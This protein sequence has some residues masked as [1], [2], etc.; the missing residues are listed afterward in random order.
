LIRGGKIPILPIHTRQDRNLAAT[1][2]TALPR[3]RWMEQ[4]TLDTT[5]IPTVAETLDRRLTAPMFLLSIV[6]LAVAAGVIH[7]VGQ[8][9]F[10]LFEVHLVAWCLAVL[11]PIFAIDAFLRFFVTRAQLGVWQRFGILVIVLLFPFVRMALRSYADPAK[12]WLPVAGWRPVDRAL[13]RKIERVFSVPLIVFALMAVPVFTLEYFFEE[14]V[15]EHFW[16]ALALD[17]ASSVI[18]MAF[19]IEFTLAVSIAERKL[20]YCIQNWMD[21]AIVVLPV[22]DF[23]PILRLWQLGRLLQLNQ[24]GRLSRMYRLRGL[25]LKAWRAIL[26][27]EMIS[28]LLGNYK[29]RRLRKLKDEVVAKQIELDELRQEIAELER[30]MAREKAVVGAEKT[31]A[32]EVPASAGELQRD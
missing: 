31:P 7:R 23:L 24:V 16:L 21:L 9:Y 25:I 2:L 32:T 8:G 3:M 1:F 30:A 19:A 15:R 29:E 14:Q 18:W 20:A 17:L 26:L 4:Q 28:R 5:S 6:Y 22:I 27:L 10:T 13:R 12:I 11:W